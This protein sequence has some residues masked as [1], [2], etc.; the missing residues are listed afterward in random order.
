MPGEVIYTGLFHPSLLFNLC[1]LV[2]DSEPDY[3][4]SWPM[5][6]RK[7]E[8]AMAP[9]PSTLA[10][11]IPWMEE[12]GRLQSMWSLG[13]RHDWVTSLSF[14]TFMHWRRK[15]KPT[16][17]FLPGESQGGGSLVGCHLWGCRVGHDWSDLIAA[18]AV[19]NC[20]SQSTRTGRISPG[21]WTPGHVLTWNSR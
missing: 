8:K 20:W 5:L 17:V 9:H 1:T 18:A 7:P 6:R 10:W 3:S 15:W 13:V 12:P 16:P 11:Q 4:A 2:T 21:C 19:G 14:F